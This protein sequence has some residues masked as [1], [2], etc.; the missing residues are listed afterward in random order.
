MVDR[1]RTS[2]L[3]GGLFVSLLFSSTKTTPVGTAG[4]PALVQAQA[5]GTAVRNPDRASATTDLEQISSL[6]ITTWKGKCGSLFFDA[7]VGAAV[8]RPP[9]QM[10]EAKCAIKVSK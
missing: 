6:A 1:N 10:L 2:I 3:A 8:K 5:Q 9:T 7:I 4:R